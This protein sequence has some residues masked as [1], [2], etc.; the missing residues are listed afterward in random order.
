[1]IAFEK[2]NGIKYRPE[3]TDRTE[4]QVRCALLEGKEFMAIEIRVVGIV[5]KKM[6]IDMLTIEYLAGCN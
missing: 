1:M 2:V 5:E 6:G 4:E 3:I